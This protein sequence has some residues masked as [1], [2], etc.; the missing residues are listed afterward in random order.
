MEPIIVIGQI[1]FALEA[2]IRYLQSTY[3]RADESP[4]D[5][6]LLWLIPLVPT[7]IGVPIE[8][9]FVQEAVSA[10]NR[11][12]GDALR[13][14]YLVHVFLSGTLLAGLVGTR[15]MAALQ[16]RTPNSLYSFHLHLL[17]VYLASYAIGYA[18]KLNTFGVWDDTVSSLFFL[19]IPMACYIAW[20]WRMNSATPET[21]AARPADDEESVEDSGHNNLNRP[22]H[23]GILP[24]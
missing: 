23:L 7:A 15:I 14:L 6:L 12:Q 1:A 3:S 10:F 19:A 22:S 5:R 9:G 16:G 24:L 8:M 11:D 2:G 4:E 21:F 18:A 20:A 13:L 17:M